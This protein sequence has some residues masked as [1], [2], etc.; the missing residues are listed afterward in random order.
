VPSAV[1]EMVRVGEV[2]DPDPATHALYDDSYRGGSP[3]IRRAEA[4]RQPTALVALTMAVPAKT[5]C[6][7]CLVGLFQVV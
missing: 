5:S 7:P 4:E 3:A 6:Q 1:G 2:R